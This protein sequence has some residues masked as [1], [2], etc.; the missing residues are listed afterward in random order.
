M[1]TANP[2]EAEEESRE[3]EQ[4]DNLDTQGEEGEGKDNGEVLCQPAC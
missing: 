3:D 2:D 4:D 1:K